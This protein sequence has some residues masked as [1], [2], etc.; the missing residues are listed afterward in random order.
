[1]GATLPSITDADAMSVHIF[2]PDAE[3][4][5][6]VILPKRTSWSVRTSPRS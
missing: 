5:L 4:T 6:L 1:M 3:N 2:H